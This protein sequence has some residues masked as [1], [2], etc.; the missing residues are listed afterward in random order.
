MDVETLYAIAQQFQL[1]GEVVA[2]EPFGTGLIYQTYRSTAQSADGVR[3]Y[4]HQRLNQAVFRQP[5]FVL[6]NMQRVTEHIR[7][8]IAE[9]DGNDRKATLRLVP[10]RDGQS[11]YRDPAGGYWRTTELIPDAVT[12]DTIQHPQHAYEAGKTLGEFQRF[13]ADL[14]PAALHDTLPGF[15][16]TPQYFQQ[17]CATVTTPHPNPAIAA[18]KQEPQA[19]DLIQ[20]T[21]ARAALAN[22]LMSP[23]QAGLLPT[24]IV[25]NDPKIN[26]IL[27]DTQTQRGLG[28]IDLDTVKG[29][30]VHFDFG[31][32]LRSAANPAGEETLDIAAVHFDL[33]IFEGITIGYLQI[34]RDVL[35]G[36][37]IY[38]L[39]QAIPVIIFEQAARFL[40]DYLRGD[41]YYP[42]I[43]YPT[44]NLQR[45]A[46]QMA[47][48]AD[49]EQKMPAIQ[50]IFHRLFGKKLPSHCST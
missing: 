35:T 45:A 4:I 39:P 37:E 17:F 30:L 47:L 28:M 27:I 48:L 16:D 14:P 41:V 25:H 6:E 34:M 50:E 2:V 44:Q 32:C 1:E 49:V 26:N 7:A 10:A 22:V 36:A 9:A 31:D 3:W 38:L 13:V 40:T 21:Q 29:G 23:W 46:V 5:L 8:K 19:Q 43:A 42:H 20:Q 18:R 12:Y 11:Y 24:R 15:H 33:A